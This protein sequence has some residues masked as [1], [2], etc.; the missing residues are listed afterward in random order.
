MSK[1]QN[2][3]G[4]SFQQGNASD[5]KL[6]TSP[7]GVRDGVTYHVQTSG[8]LNMVM[9]ERNESWVCLIGRLPANQLTDLAAKLQF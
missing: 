8:S 4:I 5:M 3:Y 6:A 7:T 9:T 2:T 1:N